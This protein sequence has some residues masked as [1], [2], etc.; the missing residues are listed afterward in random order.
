MSQIS[1][2]IPFIRVSSAALALSG[3]LTSTT[4]FAQNTYA[5]N[6]VTSTI[7]SHPLDGVF[8]QL[9]DAARTNN[10]AR[11]A[12]LADQLSGYPLTSYVDYY[13]LKPRLFNSDGTPNVNA[14]DGDI[15]QF[16]RTYAG[17]ALADRLR[18]DYALVLGARGDW[19]NFRTHYAQFN[20]KDDMQLKCYEQMANAADGQN[21][22]KTTMALLTES[23]HA[24]VRA[25]QQLVRQLAS[26]GKLSNDEINYF[27]ALSAYTSSAQGQAI[28]AYSSS[29]SAAR[30]ASLVNQANDDKGGLAGS[31]PSNNDQTSA[32]AQ[33][34][35]GYSAARRAAPDAASY[36]RN[37]Y[38]QYSRLQLP[39]DVLGWQARA[40][41]RAGDWQLVASGIDKM[42]DAEKNTAIWQYWRG[43]AYAAQG[44]RNMANM[45]YEQAARSFDFYGILAKEELGQK[46][47]LPP[48]TVPSTREEINAASRIEGFE[49]ARKFQAMNMTLEYNREWNYPL[50]GMTDRQLLAAAE[51]AR[52]IGFL[53]RMINTSDRT[54]SEFNFKQ[55]YPTPYLS[56]M[57]NRAAE[58]GITSSW[59]YGI[60]RQESRFV[61]AA[62]SH[63]NA[64][65][66]MQ[67]I[68]D[69]ARAVARRIGLSN[70]TLDQLYNIDTNI[71][72]GT[73]YLGQTKNLLGGSQPLASAGYNAGPGRPPQWRRTLTRS[74][75]GAIYAET[76]PFSETRGYVKNV[77][78]NTIYYHLLLDGS[79]PSLKSLMGTVSP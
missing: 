45:M 46:V 29:P 74:V 37:A 53:D 30:M 36:Y 4:I 76:I 41:M 51:Y 7:S 5:E 23:K 33:A 63:A 34:Y 79:A 62:K 68:P 13:R 56:I 32:L 28:A 27:A 20:L 71:Q 16:F 59:A 73:A 57:N 70:F 44:D 72:L 67:I 31:L 2:H 25:C 66:L 3:I 40:G 38:S 1:K 61:V 17:Q 52:K 35:Y 11:A 78:A 54:R 55:R 9:R 43:R 10:V 65:G 12:Q 14:P 22:T 18:N 49:R 75:D 48:N 50:R 6:P 19:R 60:I 64:N 58:A 77:M 21:V 69:T 15:E 26:S 39:D 42:T 24:N 8:A 47:S